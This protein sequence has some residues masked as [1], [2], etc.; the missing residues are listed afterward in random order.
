MVPA[1]PLARD[2]PNSAS[3]LALTASELLGPWREDGSESTNGTPFQATAVAEDA[4]GKI[5]ELS[6]KTEAQR[7][8]KDRAI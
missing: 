2:R 5:D 8:L 1:G 7:V 3:P 6:P 4:F